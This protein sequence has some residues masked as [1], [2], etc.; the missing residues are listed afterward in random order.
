MFVKKIIPFSVAFVLS[1]L[2]LEV[3]YGTKA[4]LPTIRYNEV[5][6]SDIKNNRLKIETPAQEYKEPMYSPKPVEMSLYAGEFEKIRD[7][8]VANGV[9]GSK[10]VYLFDTTDRKGNRLNLYCYTLTAP[11]RI[12]AFG[13]IGKERKEY[14]DFSYQITSKHG[15][16]TLK[17][18]SAN[19]HIDEV[20]FGFAN[21][22]LL[23]NGYN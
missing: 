5:S 18:D 19:K 23:A 4:I 15:I 20:R 13:V 16:L 12:D 11:Q 21:L 14:E 10:G 22:S 8:I 6:V 9:K 2:V 1:L 3:M 17:D 7:Y